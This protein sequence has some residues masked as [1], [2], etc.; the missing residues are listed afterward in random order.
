MKTFGDF[1]CELC[2]C[3]A[4]PI[5]PC[6]LLCRVIIPARGSLRLYPQNEGCAEQRALS[7][8]FSLHLS[9]ICSH[10]YFCFTERKHSF[11]RQEILVQLSSVLHLVPGGVL[12]SM[13]HIILDRIISR[14]Q[15]FVA[16]LIIPFL[17]QRGINIPVLQWFVPSCS[18]L[19]TLLKQNKAKLFCRDMGLSYKAQVQTSL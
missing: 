9:L 17:E 5:A 8:A 12:R 18:C 4:F 3:R 13:K 1:P 16:A 2:E 15:T 7:F 10:I 6:V 14:P 19:D 11:R